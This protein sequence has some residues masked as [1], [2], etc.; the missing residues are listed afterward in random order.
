MDELLPTDSQWSVEACREVFPRITVEAQGANALQ[1]HT[2]HT[3]PSITPVTTPLLVAMGSLGN[4]DDGIFA[5]RKPTSSLAHYYLIAGVIRPDT[6]N[7]GDTIYYWSISC[8][9]LGILSRSGSRISDPRDPG[10]GTGTEEP[11]VSVTRAQPDNKLHSTTSLV[12][13]PKSSVVLSSF[14]TITA[15]TYSAYE[16]MSPSLM[17]WRFFR[18]PNGASSSL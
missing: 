8:S 1:A 10:P 6:C 14:A 3:L 11:G 15:P 18:S 17:R 12:V 9:F 13:S 7:A 5:T 4:S 16:L 2:S